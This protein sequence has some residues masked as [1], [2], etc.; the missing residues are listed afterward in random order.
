MKLGQHIMNILVKIADQQQITIE[1]ALAQEYES[2]LFFA[3]R[4]NPDDT[5][6]MRAY[7]GLLC[8]L[9]DQSMYI[10]LCQK[11]IHQMAEADM[12]SV[13]INETLH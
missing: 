8:P 7:G 13:S 6:Y 3:L 12:Q 5:N 10:G 1:E 9:S 4:E 11:L 2:I